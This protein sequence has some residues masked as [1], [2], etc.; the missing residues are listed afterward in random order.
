MKGPGGLVAAVAFVTLAVAAP[1]AAAARPDR[2]P[3]TVAGDHAKVVGYFIEWGIYGRNYRVK[4][5]V[6][7]GSA[8]RLDVVNYAFGNVVPDTAGNVVCKLGDEWADYQKPWSADESVTGQEVTWPRPI[9]GN[10]QQLRALK[11]LYPHLKVVISLGGWTWS[12]YFSDAALTQQSRE[13]LVASCVDLFVKGNIPE[14]G[15]GG[16]GG[17]SAAAGVFDGIDL[18][19]E[20][21]G[22]EGNTG[23]IIRPEDKQNF[24]KLLAE[25]RRQLDAYGR[26]SGRDYLLTAFLPAAPSKIDAGF[27]A[28]SIFDSLDFAT[29]Q[30]YDLHGAWE[31]V[32]NHQ[33]NIWPSKSDP[34]S[35]RF[36]VDDTVKAYLV[37][38]APRSELVVGV[39]FYSRGWTG[40]N[41]ANHGLYQ[42]ASGPAP[43]VWEAGVDDYE[44][45]KSLLGSGYTRYR[46]DRADAAWLFNGTTFWTFDDPKVMKRK[47]H[48][49]KGN[50]LGGLMFWELSGDTPDG[51]LIRAIADGLS[52]A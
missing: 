2:S 52:G 39:P 13:R 20:W 27:E 44:V 36:S 33:S 1:L 42:P 41:A 6:T 16:M 50:G 15:W 51:E 34:S 21:P 14:P 25:F 37:R 4:D 31:S 30:G 23:N 8:A 38:G 19:W 28:G 10:F 11:Q 18:D 26:V 29:V 17:P 35:P 3:A 47:A 22:S 12:K 32:T 45:A 46:D 43:G 9:L 40:V 49:V 5:V 48:Y 24:T 7:S